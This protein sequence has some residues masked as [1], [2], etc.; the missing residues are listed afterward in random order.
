MEFCFIGSIVC[1]TQKIYDRTQNFS[2]AHELL[3]SDHC[4]KQVMIRKERKR[5]PSGNSFCYEQNVLEVAG[6][7]TQRLKEDIGGGLNTFHIVT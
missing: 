6:I 2:T 7:A 5:Q 3:S 1:T 4:L